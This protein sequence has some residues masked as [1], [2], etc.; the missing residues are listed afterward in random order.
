MLLHLY[1]IARSV[2]SRSPERSEG[3][4]AIPKKGW[5]Y[6]KRLPRGACPERHEILRYAQNDTKRRAR[7]DTLSLSLRGATATKQ[8]R[9]RGET[10][11]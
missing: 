2:V 4:D 9:G 7:N 11:F 1:V 5:N 6:C 10:I 3:D 8:S